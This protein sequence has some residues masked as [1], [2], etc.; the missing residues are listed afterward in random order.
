MDGGIGMASAL[1]T[2]GALVGR[3]LIMAENL[4]GVSTKCADLVQQLKTLDGVLK[5]VDQEFNRT[6]QLAV[7]QPVP[8]MGLDVTKDLLESCISDCSRTCGQYEVLLRKI[9]TSSNT[10]LRWLR[11][12]GE[13]ARLHLCLEARKSTL[14]TVL[15]SIRYPRF[16]SNFIGVIFN[17]KQERPRQLQT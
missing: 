6:I 13:L 17:N 11:S 5:Y 16:N 4:R 15:V 12:E 7:S 8:S 3:V 1:V 9:S 10:K 14:H 2:L